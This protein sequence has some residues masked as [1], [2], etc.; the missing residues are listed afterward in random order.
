[1][2][3]GALIEPKPA[4]QNEAKP[5]SK[6][7]AEP[8]KAQDKQAATP[9]KETPTKEKDQKKEGPEKV[10]YSP[11]VDADGKP[12]PAPILQGT[13]VYKQ[14]KAQPIPAAVNQAQVVQPS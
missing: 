7:E 2:K 13:V 12:L 4:V 3:A 9:Q 5:D 14:N 1:M 8:A 11:G 10:E 6:V